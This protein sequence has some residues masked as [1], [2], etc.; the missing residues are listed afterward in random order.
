MIKQDRNFPSFITTLK[1]ENKISREVFTIDLGKNLFWFGESQH[2]AKIF[3]ILDKINQ[4]PQ[5]SA[6]SQRILEL[7]PSLNKVFKDFIVLSS[8]SRFSYTFLANA[9]AIN[10]DV[11]PNTEMA[12]IHLDSGNTLLAFPDTMRPHFEKYLKDCTLQDEGIETFK[13][14]NCPKSVM[15]AE[16]ELQV[17]VTS[18]LLKNQQIIDTFGDEDF[19]K[20]FDQEGAF[21]FYYYVDTLEI[22]GFENYYY[23]YTN[24]LL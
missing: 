7:A 6:H 5:V 4:T 13:Y 18:K 15:D 23:Y 21:R 11:I 24:L 16:F 19:Q 8:L 3:K 14:L 17:K 12:S 20:A 9:L 22:L 2:T 1:D 10:G